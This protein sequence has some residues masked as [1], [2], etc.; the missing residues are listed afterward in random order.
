MAKKTEKTEKKEEVKTTESKKEK[1]TC[2][3][4]GPGNKLAE[5]ANRFHCGKC[6]YTRWKEKEKTG[7]A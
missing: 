1:Q 4:C 3:K 7:A 6:G 5:H 2:P